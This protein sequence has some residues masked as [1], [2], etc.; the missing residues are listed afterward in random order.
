MKHKKI[1]SGIITAL[2]AIL[3]LAFTAAPNLGAASLNGSD[4]IE[5]TVVGDE[6]Q[7]P[8]GFEVRVKGDEELLDSVWEKVKS[9]IITDIPENAV[10]TGKYVS[11]REEGSGWTSEITETHC[12]YYFSHIVDGKKVPGDKFIVIIDAD[13]LERI[14]VEFHT[15]LNEAGSIEAI[16]ASRRSM[17]WDGSRAWEGEIKI[18]PTALIIFG[19]G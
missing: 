6:Q 5:V 14:P 17:I 11:G 3:V 15:P 1:W 16:E 19:D 10:L 8:D 2:V 7:L 12:V 9:S 4:D 18:L 13:T